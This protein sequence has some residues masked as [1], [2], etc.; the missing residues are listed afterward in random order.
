VCETISK[1][2]STSDVASAMGVG[3]SSVKRWIDA[4]RLAAKKTPGGHRRVA[5]TELYSFI[6]SS[7]KKLV[8]PGALGIKSL[9]TGTKSPLE[10]C[11]TSLATGDSFTF[12]STLQMLRIG[13]PTLAAVVDKVVYPALQ[14]LRATCQHPS[15]ECLTLHRTIAMTQTALGASL[16][17]DRAKMDKKSPRVVLADIGY[18]V[19][20]I[21]TIL[22]EA[23]ISDQAHC[24]QLGTNVPVTVINGA[25]KSYGADLLWL[26]ASGPVRRSLIESAFEDILATAKRSDLKVVVFGDAVPRS[27]GS[28]AIH[29]SSFGEF[30][31]YVTALR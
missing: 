29:L 6:R 2:F 17:S 5:L 21:P 7:G 15:E 8:D 11:Q 3:E 30:R 27:L 12:E 25:L 14:A 16:T 31:G 18:E 20:G 1:Y 28:S 19:D 4:G 13:E 26:S 10:V 22:A 9:L 23:S 24:L